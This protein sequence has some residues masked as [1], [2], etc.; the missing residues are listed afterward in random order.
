MLLNGWK[1]LV[2]ASAGFGL[3]LLLSG[4]A[5]DANRRLPDPTP[6]AYDRPSLVKVMEE[7]DER[8]YAVTSLVVRTNIILHDHVKDKHV[9]LNG[10]YLGDKEGNLR[11]QI[12]YNE[13]AIMDL[14]IHGEE[15]DLW[16]PRKNR[17]FRGT[18]KD[19]LAATECELSLL[20]HAG[21][22]PDLFFPRAWTTEVANV[23][24]QRR[25]GFE[26]GHEVVKV[27][28]RPGINWRCVRQVHISM[29][30]PVADLVE[31]FSRAEKCVGR[32]KYEDYR[33]PGP[34][35]GELKRTP[36]YPGRVTLIPADESRSLEMNVE[37]LIPNTPI[38]DE[39]FRI[40]PPEDVK[41]LNL[42]E[43][44]GSGKSLWE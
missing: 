42:G 26:H 12:R 40:K 39:K 6:I 41:V 11:L 43:Q 30:Q 8:R 10:V 28:E 34:T 31:V 1:G 19:L 14:A 3:L 44:L 36:P 18:K 38:D 21:N 17:F 5:A 20:A 33:F 2:Q 27:Y 15:V 37:E 24:T 9:G 4:C 29:E 35:A 7:M 16:L 22:M 13:T 23:D 32:I 25:G